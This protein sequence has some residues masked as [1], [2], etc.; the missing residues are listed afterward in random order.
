LDAVPR[1]LFF[2]AL[3][4]IAITWKPKYYKK[5]NQKE[6]GPDVKKI[7][8]NHQ[9]TIA[10]VKMSQAKPHALRPPSPTPQPNGGFWCR[11]FHMV[12][13]NTPRKDAKNMPEN[14]ATKLNGFRERAG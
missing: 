6:H 13:Q 7:R 4:R 8:R 2:A 3:Q 1:R 9:K 12:E 14:H 10:V 5:K 11:V